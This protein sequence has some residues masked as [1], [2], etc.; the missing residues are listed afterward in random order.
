ARGGAVF[1]GSGA[2]VRRSVLRGIA[3]PRG[4]RRS[5]ELRWS[6]K[7]RAAG[8][9]LVAP[10]RPI[11]SAASVNAERAV[12][13]ERRR[14]VRAAIATLLSRHDPLWTFGL[15]GA[16]RVGYLAWMVRPLSGLRRV[17]FV[18]I[19]VACLVTGTSPI[20]PQSSVWIVAGLWAAWFVLQGWAIDQCSD[21]IL[22]PGDRTRWSM[23]TMGASIAALF[24]AGRAAVGE[25]MDAARP[26]GWRGP[27][28]H[29][30]LVFALLVVSAGSI[31]IGIDR[32]HSFLSRITSA[33]TDPWTR[34]AVAVV[35]IWTVALMLDVMRCLI[36]G[37]QLRAAQRLNVRLDATID[38]N[39][40][41]ITNLSPRGVG[42]QFD[43][44]A[45]L[46]VGD[47]VTV[48]F[49]VPTGSE[50]TAEV[51][52]IA[53][54]RSIRHEHTRRTFGISC[55]LEF[56]AMDRVSADALFAYCAVVHPGSP[57]EALDQ[58]PRSDELVAGPVSQQ[59]F[60]G[61][62]LAGATAL[63]GIGAAMMPPFGATATADVDP[64]HIVTVH[65]TDAIRGTGIAG[66]KVVATCVSGQRVVDDGDDVLGLARAATSQTRSQQRSRLAAADQSAADR[67]LRREHL[68]SKLAAQEARRDQRLADAVAVADDPNS[69]GDDPRSVGWHHV[70]AVQTEDSKPITA[71][72]EGDGTYVLTDLPGWPCR[73][74]AGGLPD[75][76]V[77]AP[78]GPHNGG[79]VQ[80]AVGG[81]TLAMASTSASSATATTTPIVE[82]GNRVWADADG[83]GLQDPAEPGLAGVPVTL[84]I[85]GVAHT[86]TTG[87]DG[88]YRFTNDPRGPTALGIESNITD[89]RLG[90]NVQ[91]SVPVTVQPGTTPLHVTIADAAGTSSVVGA[92]IDSAV[93]PARGA[94]T[95]AVAH[96]VEHDIDIGYT[97]THAL[98]DRVWLDADNDGLFG[99]GEQGIDGVTVVLYLDDDADGV[100]D[101]RP[102][103]AQVTTQGGLY[104]FGDLPAG[105]YVVE[106]H[107]P[108][109][110]VSSTGA[111]GRVDGPYEPNVASAA[112]VAAQMD[113]DDNGLMASTGVIRSGTVTLGDG[114]SP[115]GEVLAPDTTAG[116]TLSGVP[117]GRGDA[118][119]DFGLFPSRSIDDAVWFDQDGNGTLSPDEPGLG[120]V[121][122][123]LLKGDT[124]VATTTSD[125][126]GDFVFPNLI[127]GEYSVL[128]YAPA[129]LRPVEALPPLTDDGELE[130]APD[131]T[132][133][134]STTPDGDAV[135]DT[136]AGTGDGTEID[137]ALDALDGVI[138][139]VFNGVVEQSGGQTT[140]ATDPSATDPGATDPNAT[141][142]EPT[143]ADTAP[144]P[145]E[146]LPT[147][148]VHV[149]VAPD[150]AGPDSGRALQRFGMWAPRSIGNSV[151]ED[152][153]DDGVI[154]AGE[155][156]IPGVQVS[157]LDEGRVV[158]HMLSA[159]DGTYRFV[160]L[161]DGTYRVA[162]DVPPTW[163]TSS[164]GWDDA[165]AVEAG[166]DNGIQPHATGRALS[167][168]IKI[169]RVAVDAVGSFERADIGLFQP[170]PSMTVDAS[171]RGTASA[172]G[173]PAVPVTAGST[174][175]FSSLVTNTGNV[176]LSGVTVSDDSPA[177]TSS[178]AI[179][180]NGTDAGD[181]QP[182]L[183]D[184]GH[185]VT[186]TSTSVIA[187]G[188]GH[189]TVTVTATGES[190][191]GTP[192]A[193]VPVADTVKWAGSAPGLALRTLVTVASPGADADG[194][195]TIDAG[196]VPRL[197][198]ID[199]SDRTAG[200]DRTANH[201]V[202]DGIRVWWVY[203]VQ[204]TGT[205]ALTGVAVTDQQRGRVCGGL[206]LA[207][208]E[209]RFCVAPE[210]LSRT[211]TRNGQAQA[212]AAAT[213]TDLT[214]PLL[215]KQVGPVADA[216]HAYVVQPAIEVSTTVDGAQAQAAPITVM[217]GSP[218]D[219]AYT[220]TNTGDVAFDSVALSDSQGGPI[221]CPELS[222][223]RGGLEPGEVVVC[224]VE[225]QSEVPVATAGAPVAGVPV[226]VV[227]HIEA[228]P[229]TV[230]GGDLP[231][232]V[233]EASWASEV[234]SL[235]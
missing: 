204:N 185:S 74:E 48:R 91:I 100:P 227:A 212:V 198:A 167:S 70:P 68:P 119:I 229:A 232:V 136:A 156:P 196:P 144:V 120:N 181:G 175:T 155:L 192:A 90:S 205:I 114:G 202:A 222:V 36:G 218:I 106:V 88:S 103:D 38:D 109:G 4:A 17:I 58:R 20:E 6:I 193:L 61:V 60:M 96:A 191:P 210:T 108:E 133:P 154:D 9:Q 67:N 35:A 71:S 13:D 219:V 176:P 163:R 54:V 215:P 2:M 153:D 5:A 102:L 105:R 43:G 111:I 8:H 80:F 72:D 187:S 161:P 7:V 152:A 174:V 159:I 40:A 73:V 164:L 12:I 78:L 160:D 26:G 53:T 142:T 170:R 138:D 117:D 92:G 180:C 16:H 69:A 122:L 57:A 214:D 200:P 11:V 83:D 235:S 127:L 29:R 34:A 47:Q 141:P 139:G 129:G 172:D 55:G 169:G 46:I 37:P 132:D 49:L 41:R 230:D 221:D 94:S 51:A 143:I 85:D 226:E 162:V 82:I 63:L 118:T 42:V 140:G 130:T 104:A 112:G 23:R 211:A 93:D 15:R 89:L 84:T 208:G 45:D 145:A 213:A 14:G 98:G 190:S 206:S 28:C 115:S 183:L 3:V 178:G 225:R 128:V 234:T 125:V 165:A 50:T 79:L 101:G 216:A 86:V 179:D 173:D 56:G 149:T 217:A 107:P 110:M 203:E 24:G 30:F 32:W 97:Q 121:P 31:A 52:T 189:R 134:E 131:V 147:E 184:V 1:L 76:G 233:V 157:L 168:P 77:A 150:W 44:G 194:D 207:P 151:W 18:G 224:R 123:V 137:P 166:L 195:G 135:T 199:D 62:R 75:G 171:L 99:A 59:R 209:R 231:T 64:S 228:E 25:S 33:D 22:R 116:A 65:L 158:A 201:V 182:L 19:L 113:D 124:I 186:C 27:G 66:A 148:V 87:A 81:D 188:P 146:D 126:D 197:D 223:G 177:G 21:G 95:F 39:A 10:P 220:V